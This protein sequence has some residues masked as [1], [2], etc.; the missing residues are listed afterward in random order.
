[1]DYNNMLEFPTFGNEQSGLLTMIQSSVVNSTSSLPF[2]IKRVLI[3]KGM[4]SGSVRGGHTHHKTR[5]ILFAIS[6][7]CAV[8]L[9]DGKHKK[10]VELNVCNAGLVLEP[11]MWHVM[12]DFSQDAVLLVLA[13]TEYDEADYIR[14]Y[15][16]FL[17][18]IQ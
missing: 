6:G 2:E 7:S 4:S 12:K 18:N 13:N 17:K 11:Y 8:D 16:Q 14:D 10:T 3:L 15:D 1:M 5:Q 9:D